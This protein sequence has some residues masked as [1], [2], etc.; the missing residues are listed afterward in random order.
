[1]VHVEFSK[2]GGTLNINAHIVGLLYTKDPNKVPLISEPPCDGAVLQSLGVPQ[3]VPRMERSTW[4]RDMFAWPAALPCWD[5][6]A[7]ATSVQERAF[8]Q[9]RP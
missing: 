5:G 9:L 3:R 2:I 6:R 4:T 7:M 1:M 8:V